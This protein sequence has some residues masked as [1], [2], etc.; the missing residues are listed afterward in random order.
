MQLLQ[1]WRQRTGISEAMS[2]LSNSVLLFRKNARPMLQI[3]E[4]EVWNGEVCLLPCPVYSHSVWLTNS[5]VPELELQAVNVHQ[6]CQHSL[7][8]E[9]S[10]LFGLAEAAFCVALQ[11]FAAVSNRRQVFWERTFED[12]CA[13]LVS[14]WP[15]SIVGSA[16]GW[17]GVVWVTATYTVHESDT[18]HQACSLR[19]KVRTAAIMIAPCET[20]ALSCSCLACLCVYHPK[21]GLLVL[22]LLGALGAVWLSWP[23]STFCTLLLKKSVIFA[24]VPETAAREL[25]PRTVFNACGDTLK[26]SKPK[27]HAEIEKAN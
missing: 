20:G 3:H 13:P 12:D 9:R 10:R 16:A 6:W 4:L 22:G 19:S 27:F 2:T 14:F 25:G 5:F 1:L 26:A 8:A 7:V 24:G 21:V 15:K 18:C 23:L 17:S 11:S